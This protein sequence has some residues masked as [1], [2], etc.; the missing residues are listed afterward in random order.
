M[1][2]F[3]ALSPLLIVA[4]LL[5]GLRWPASR[6][7]PLSLL[8]AIVA[9]KWVWQV[10]D[11]QIA[12]AG[13]KGL[14]ITAELLSII[15]FALLMLKTLDRS[16]G[17]DVIRRGFST[18]SPD[19]RV[20][21]I[22][23]AW[24]FGSF[25]EGAAGFG[26]PA[27]VAVPLLI[28]LRFPPL[29]A[30][31]CGMMI[32]CTPVS[33]GALGT[34]IV[35]GVQTGLSA[36]DSVWADAAERFEF[37]GDEA[38]SSRLTLMLIAGRVAMV[39][40]A[41]GT[42]IPLAMACMLTRWFGENR[43]YREGLQVWR[44]AV[45]AGLSMTIPYVAV[46]HTL[47]PEF[48][49]LFGGMIGM[50]FMGIGLRV[51]RSPR[52]DATTWSFAERSEAISKTID[53][54]GANDPV[55][56][57][58]TTTS[59]KTMS[60]ASAWMPYV[61]LGG[62]LV[63]TRISSLPLSR[64][65]RSDAVTFRFENVFGSAVSISSMPLA[66]PSFVFAAAVAIT[67][68]MHRLPTTQLFAAVM[69]S[70]RTTSKASVALLFTVPMVQIFL[71]SSGG[72]A[73]LPSMPLV[74]AGW[75][76]G[77]VGQAWPMVAPA[78]GGLGAFVAGS[79]TISN[80]MLSSFQYGVGLRIG[81][82]PFW[83]VALQAVGGAAGNTICVHNVVSACAVANLVGEEGFVIR[84]TLPVFLFYAAAAGII[85]MSLALAAH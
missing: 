50:I 54:A 66:L 82:D 39:H 10:G 81:A 76:A 49:S 31:M 33:F 84:R 44:F 8:A 15:F 11:G 78:V 38:S 23:V 14:V 45:A 22:L 4:V 55:I 40:A 16:G 35:V 37:S 67:V 71:N 41:I 75:T 62:L 7:M 1:L 6:V 3:F 46:A 83:I 69:D 74:L 42:F 85:G 36:T 48:P 80:M 21:A 17:L 28:A 77:R 26:T 58:P 30:V 52:S 70:F 79:N 63:L 53:V 32:Q 19:P 24:L 20:Q 43:S 51:I 65:I 29:A 13:L 12:A 61:V 34:P 68:L 56:E 73:E 57:A 5:V 18:L 47:G 2:I 27:A 72:A 9:A 60:L 64:W 59:T 25:I